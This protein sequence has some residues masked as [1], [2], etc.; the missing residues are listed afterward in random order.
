MTTRREQVTDAYLLGLAAL[1][2]EKLATLDQNIPIDAV[3]GGQDA[4][5]II[6]LTTH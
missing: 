1:K 5:E 4:L 6:C 2:G 3:E